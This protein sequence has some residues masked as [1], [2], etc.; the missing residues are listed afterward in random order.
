MP[1]CSSCEKKF[2]HEK[3]LKVHMKNTHGPQIWRKCTSCSK[4]YK[5]PNNFLVHY[6]KEHFQKCR[7]KKSDLKKMCRGCANK[8]QEEKI[9]WLT[10]SVHVSQKSNQEKPHKCPTCEKCFTTK[11]HL[12]GH[13]KTAHGPQIQRKCIACSQKHKEIKNFLAHYKKVH[14]KKCHNKKCVSKNMCTVC[15]SR[16][17]EA[18]HG[19]RTNIPPKKVLRILEK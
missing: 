11:S 13:A 6:K 3:H 4:A 2:K 5:Q 8:M 17:K 18:K 19:W 1:P 15:A 10:K 7:N 14:L 12:K 16:L 9:R